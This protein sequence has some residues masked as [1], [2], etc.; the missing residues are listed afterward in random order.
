MIKI[1]LKGDL[2]LDLKV[3][4]LKPGDLFLAT[5]DKEKMY[6]D[7]RRNGHTFN[8]V[9]YEDNYNIIDE[10]KTLKGEVSALIA[11]A[12]GNVVKP[13][14][15][16][17]DFFIRNSTDYARELIKQVFCK[18]DPAIDESNYEHLPEY[19]KLCNYLIN[20]QG[21]GLLLAG[22]PGTGKSNIIKHLVPM[23]YRMREKNVF[24]VSCYDLH[25][26]QD[27]KSKLTIYD[28]ARIRR[29]IILDEMG[30]EINVNDYGE[31]FNPVERLINLSD[32][33]NKALFIS[34]NLSDGEI[35]NRY[36]KRAF[37]RLTKRTLKIEFTTKSK[38]K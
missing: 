30:V 19:D 15:P 38:R 8:C 31:K 13:S 21:K 9:V 6:F 26:P 10:I 32:D 23:L 34:T 22:N 36:G 12:S 5:K 33:E 37:D 11:A 28:A 7:V 25:K 35:F 20:T 24:S 4:G 27:E 16:V 2:D 14:N 1:E 29:H 17:P 3:L 18:F